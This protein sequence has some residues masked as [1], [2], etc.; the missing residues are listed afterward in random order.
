MAGPRRRDGHDVR[1]ETAHD[2][3]GEPVPEGE[4][5]DR[6]ERTLFSVLQIEG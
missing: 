1:I 5:L 4:L 3:L 2:A 6:G